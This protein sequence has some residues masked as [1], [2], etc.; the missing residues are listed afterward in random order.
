M[1]SRS[2]SMTQKDSSCLVLFAPDGSEQ[3]ISDMI[4]RVERRVDDLCFVDSD[5]A[6]EIKPLMPVE[7]IQSVEPEM[8][9]TESAMLREVARV[10]GYEEARRQF[11]EELN[12]R[13]AEE[14]QRVEQMRR[15]FARD[16]QRFFAAA[17]SQVV[18]LALAVARKILARDAELGELPL[19]ATVKAALGRVQDGSSTVLRVP[20]EEQ[21][22]WLRMFPQG[23]SGNSISGSVTVLADG[24]LGP[25]ECVL[26]TSVGRVEVGLDVQMSEVERGF[27]ELMQ[28]EEVE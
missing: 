27:R 13:L 2:D 25:A 11:V 1:I 18:Q 20:A 17:E 28:N 22:A 3:R 4:T 23:I 15:E 5:A 8:S 6:A 26:E 21:D 10:E 16:R 7:P 14:R 9:G 19:R 12:L 24:G